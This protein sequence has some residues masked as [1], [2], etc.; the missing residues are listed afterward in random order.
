MTLSWSS[1]SLTARP[2][3]KP[4]GIC[5]EIAEMDQR[6]T[7]FAAKR[8]MDLLGSVALLVLLAPLFLLIAALIKLDDGGP[9]LFTQERV[10]SRRRRRA[11]AGARAAGAARGCLTARRRGSAGVASALPIRSRR[12]GCTAA[13]R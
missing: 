3:G 4:D 12:R 11:I 6:S 7:Y 10:G 8:A 13:T 5:L 1:S 9:V 2:P